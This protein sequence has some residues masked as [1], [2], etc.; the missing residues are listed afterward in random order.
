[1]AVEGEIK[2]APF[3]VKQAFNTA[4]DVSSHFM[5]DTKLQ[6]K[7]ICYALNKGRPLIDEA[8]KAVINKL[9]DVVSTEGFRKG[10]YTR[11]NFKRR[12]RGRKGGAVDIHKAIG[13]LPKY[14]GGWTLPGHKYTRPYN[15]LDNQLKYD[16]ETGEIL[17]I[18]DQPTG[19]TDAIAMQRIVDYAVCGD[20]KKCKH[21]AD[22][23]MVR[24]LDAVPWNEKRWGHWLARNIINTKR[25][26]GLGAEK[27]ND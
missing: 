12:G 11:K 13:K 24:A 27:K 21:V 10:E 16:P 5:R 22:R 9:A 19:K 2:A 20:D 1:L 8:G 15:D 7:A 26:V 6:Q 14:K 18:Y 4:R 25:K 23:K 17:E 3:I